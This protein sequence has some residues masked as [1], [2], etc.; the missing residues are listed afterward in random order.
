MPANT[1]TATIDE[2]NTLIQANFGHVQDINQIVSL[3][4]GKLDTYVGWDLGYMEFDTWLKLDNLVKECQKGLWETYAEL[5]DHPED[6]KCYMCC[7]DSTMRDSIR[8]MI[9][10]LSGHVAEAAEDWKKLGYPRRHEDWRDARINAL[11]DLEERLDE[12]DAED[13]PEKWG[14][15]PWDEVDDLMAITEAVS[16]VDAAFEQKRRLTDGRERHR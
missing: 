8:E 6:C 2:L 4:R 13:P 3:M 9:V 10:I 12:L 11:T 7:E 16:D 1:L 14:P 15:G 5:G